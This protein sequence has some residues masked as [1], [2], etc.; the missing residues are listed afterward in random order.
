MS[1]QEE[2]CAL[3]PSVAMCSHAF[4]ACYISRLFDLPWFHIWNNRNVYNFLYPAVILRFLFSK[5]FKQAP[6]PTQ[7]R[8]VWIPG[9]FS[10]GVKRTGRKANHLP[11]FSVVKMHRR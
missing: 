8:V 11:P 7:P 1:T 5:A 3:F 6:G 10:P 2:A 9:Y 4:H